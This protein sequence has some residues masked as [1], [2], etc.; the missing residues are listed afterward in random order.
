MR[1]LIVE[2]ELDVLEFLRAYCLEQGHQVLAA[3]TVQEALAHLQHAI[4]DVAL[5]DLRLPQ[6]HG[7]MVVR[8]IAQRHLPTRMV[9]I[10]GDDDLELRQELKA[11]GVA[12]YLFKPV[13][14][15]DLEVALA[16]CDLEKDGNIPPPAPSNGGDEHQA[17]DDDD[18]QREVA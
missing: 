9:V 7:R 13:T 16:K 4:P 3:S 18:D 8:D 1:L 6:G 15:V 11:E 14:I 10:T 2:D 5:V 17:S 12:D